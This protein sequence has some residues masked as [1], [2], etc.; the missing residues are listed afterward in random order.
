MEQQQQQQ[1]QVQE[2][3]QQSAQQQSFQRK[4]FLVYEVCSLHI[5]ANKPLNSSI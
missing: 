2:F 5:A 4:L 3:S 1:Q